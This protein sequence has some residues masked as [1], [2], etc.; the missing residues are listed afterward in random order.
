MRRLLIAGLIALPL[1]CSQVSSTKVKTAAIQAVYSVNANESGETEVAA[2]LKDGADYVSLSG[3]DSIQA[4]V[5]AMETPLTGASNLY[6]QL[7]YTAELAVNAPGT[8]IAVELQRASPNVSALN[9]SVA[10]PSDF[11]AVTDTTDTLSRSTDTITVYWDTMPLVG[12]SMSW[13]AT[14]SCIAQSNGEIQD[15]TTQLVIP[16]GTLVTQAD[17]PSDGG[18]PTTCPVTITILRQ[19]LGNIDPALHS[20]SSLIGYQSRSLLILSSM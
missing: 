2:T 3:G 16:P 5:N 9:S 14:G 4:V 15:A 12:E 1:A 10:L 8:V 20:G 11:N 18:T 7:S 17:G 13:V 6:G 19:R